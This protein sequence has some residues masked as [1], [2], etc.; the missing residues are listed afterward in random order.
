MNKQ[1]FFKKLLGQF[2]IPFFQ[3]L[4][5]ENPWAKNTSAK[6]EKKLFSGYSSQPLEGSHRFTWQAVQR[7]IMSLLEKLRT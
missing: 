1:N 2:S 4:M 7:L 5:S 3:P 6:S